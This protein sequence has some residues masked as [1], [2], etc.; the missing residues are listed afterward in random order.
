MFGD[1]KEFD[2]DAELLRFA[3]DSVKIPG[4]YLEFGVCTGTTIN[5]LAALN[6]KK[7]IYGFDSFEGIPER[8]VNGSDVYKAYSFAY[9]KK[10]L[11]GN[12]IPLYTLRNVIVYKG[13][14]SH[15]L[16]LFK[17]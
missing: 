12:I 3:S 10:H 6:P 13:W 8:W 1:A 15:T 16:P 5:F 17:E 2:N 11:E 9:D 7:T 4:A 14:F